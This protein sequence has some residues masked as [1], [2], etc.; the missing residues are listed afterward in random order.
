MVSADMV[1]GHGQHVCMRVH[2]RG[3]RAQAASEY[4]RCVCAA[5]QAD[6][7]A[8]G[9]EHASPRKGTRSHA[10]C[11]SAPP[12]SASALSLLGVEPAARGDS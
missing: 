3:R 6:R 2:A 8:G 5:R 1:C 4:A 10:P 7:G 11:Q 12:E 9:I